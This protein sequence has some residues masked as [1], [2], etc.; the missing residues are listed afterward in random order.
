MN[1]DTEIA[2]HELDYPDLEGALEGIE[3]ILPIALENVA[4][5]PDNLGAAFDYARQRLGF[6]TALE[7]PPADIIE[8]LRTIVELGVALFRRGSFG[9]DTT[10]TLSIGGA[11][12]DVAGGI[13]YYNSAPRWADAVGAAMSLRD[14]QSLARLCEF[15]VRSFEGSYDDYMNDYARA[16]IAFVTK[17]DDAAALFERMADSAA[18]AKKFPER[19]RRLGVPLAKV[20]QAVIRGDEDTF[21]VQLAE[22]LIW[23]STLHSRA[24][25]KHEAGLVVPLQFLGWAARAHDLGLAVRVRS[26]YLPPWLVDG[27]FRDAG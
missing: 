10:V 15:D 12:I 16:V 18:H 26:G 19:G 20:A 17:A 3:E 9:P 2:A 4:T 25:E 13:S 11:C 21:D 7:R 22:G 24:P 14:E 6:R 1:A 23:Y 5:V 8:A 27:S